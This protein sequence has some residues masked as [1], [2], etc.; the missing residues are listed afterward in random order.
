M[1]TALFL[2][3]DQYADWEG[4]Y[5]ASQINQNP[6]WQVKTASTTSLVTSIGGFTTKVDYQL[7]DLPTIDLLILIGGNSWNI[8]NSAL[9]L[10]VQQHLN[11]SK[12]IGAICGAVD[13][14][15]QNGFLTGYQ[16][17]G[18]SQ[19]L[20]QTYSNYQNSNDFHNQQV[21]SDKN[22]VTANGTAALAFTA[23]VLQLIHFQSNETL[24]QTID[25]YRLG[26]Y[27]YCQKYG[28]PFG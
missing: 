22:L 18:N 1:K 28:N 9:Y 2:M 10:L 7:D 14:L 21:I 26:F 17:T 4:S 5:L 15:A 24:T 20:W 16:H 23:A 6:D 8:N 25:L 12:P 27:Q 11:T 3:L 13:Y 19:A